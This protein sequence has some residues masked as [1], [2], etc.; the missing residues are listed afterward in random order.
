MASSAISAG[1]VNPYFLPAELSR[2]STKVLD[3][4]R[5]CRETRLGNGFRNRLGKIA[6]LF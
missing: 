1:T 5:N 2:T 4:L 6:L 3:M